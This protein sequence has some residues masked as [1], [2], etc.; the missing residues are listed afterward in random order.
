MPQLLDFEVSH[1]EYGTVTVS[2]IGPDS[3][4]IQA[5]TERWGLSK[6]EWAQ[7]AA[8]I[9]VRKLGMTLKARCRRCGKEIGMPGLCESCTKAEEQYR[10]DAARFRPQDRRAGYRERQ[11]TP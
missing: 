1:P 4:S 11:R 5:A 8:R 9:D 6:S 10:R 2:S 7:I 3:A